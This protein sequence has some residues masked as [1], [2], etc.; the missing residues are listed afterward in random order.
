MMNKQANT[1][2]P[3]PLVRRSGMTNLA[4]RDE[5]TSDDPLPFIIEATASNPDGATRITEVRQETHDD[6]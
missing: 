3:F 1:F 6:Q 2:L 5:N 4:Y